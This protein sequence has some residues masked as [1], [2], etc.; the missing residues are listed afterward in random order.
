[1]FTQVT[2][3]NESGYE[4]SRR[5][6][7]GTHARALEAVIT[8]HVQHTPDT[9]KNKTPFAVKVKWICSKV[10]FLSEQEE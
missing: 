8:K 10:Y 2:T 7:R 3:Q 9:A 6:V 4:G 1:M 5:G